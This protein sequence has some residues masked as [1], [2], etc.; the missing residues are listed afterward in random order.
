MAFSVVVK[1]CGKLAKVQLTELNNQGKPKD[2]RCWYTNINIDGIDLEGE[3]VELPA[4]LI[5]EAFGTLLSMR[6]D[7]IAAEELADA[8]S[9]AI[10]EAADGLLPEDV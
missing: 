1:W 4:G 3:S 5:E 6:E 10:L 9:Q 2:G 8:L 7:T